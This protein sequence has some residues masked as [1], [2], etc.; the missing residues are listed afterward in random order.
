MSAGGIKTKPI[1]KNNLIF[2]VIMDADKKC[3]IGIFNEFQ[4]AFSHIY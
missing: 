2:F 3:R 1:I 4:N